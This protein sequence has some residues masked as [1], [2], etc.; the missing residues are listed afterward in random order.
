MR[1]MARGRE[2]GI[3]LS[4]VTTMGM[5]VDATTAAAVAAMDGRSARP[6][7]FFSSRSH[8][9]VGPTSS[10]PTCREQRPPF[11]RFVSLPHSPAERLHTNRHQ[12]YQLHQGALYM[13]L[14]YTGLLGC[15]HGSPSAHDASHSHHV[16]R[17]L[18]RSPTSY[19][20]GLRLHTF[21][22]PSLPS[23]LQIPFP[24]SNTVGGLGSAISSFS[25]V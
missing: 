23:S 10:N 5:H 7:V 14:I 1:C 4:L 18:K 16:R 11:R 22:W 17:G 6:V 2:S 19:L 25:E 15:M 9:Y 12:S 20:A 8:S 24:A 21:R 3:C 13:V